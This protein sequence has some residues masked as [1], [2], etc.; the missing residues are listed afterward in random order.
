MLSSDRLSTIV[1]FIGFNLIQA[2]SDNGACRILE[3]VTVELENFSTSKEC[4]TF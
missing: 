2:S 4:G 3:S 1:N